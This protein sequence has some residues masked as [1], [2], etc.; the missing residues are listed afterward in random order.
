VEGGLHGGVP[1]L[2]VRRHGGGER[3]E[4]LHEPD[5]WLGVEG[6]PGGGGRAGAHHRRRC[7]VRAGLAQQ[8][9]AAREAR[10]GARVTAAHPRGGRRRG[11]G[12]Q[13][14]RRR[15]GTRTAR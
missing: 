14:D 7:L 2:P 8:P 3:G 9:D 1:L 12:V 5:P 13:G 15:G 4:L 10:G 11:G 6:V